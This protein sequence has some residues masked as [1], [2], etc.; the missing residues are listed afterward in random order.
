MT[1]LPS[2]SSQEG[3]PLPPGDLVCTLKEEDVV[4]PA[5]RFRN[6]VRCCSCWRAERMSGGLGELQCEAA[7]WGELWLP[8]FAFWLHL[9]TELWGWHIRDPAGI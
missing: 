9:V 8:Y 2:W 1:P 3:V 7:V 5:R 6:G 4:D